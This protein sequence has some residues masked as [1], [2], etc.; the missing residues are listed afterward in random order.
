MDMQRYCPNV[1]PLPL[2]PKVP[3]T[4]CIS[5]SS[6]AILR[7]H[8]SQQYPNPVLRQEEFNCKR[9]APIDGATESHFPVCN[10]IHLSLFFINHRG[11]SK[12]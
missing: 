1:L 5:T 4:F 6:V 2:S 9:E 3:N 10:A 11:G 12:T 7:I 8:A